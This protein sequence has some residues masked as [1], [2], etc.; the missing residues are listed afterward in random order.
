MTQREKLIAKIRARPAE[1]DAGDVI[2]VLELFGWR[3]DR[4]TGSHM[5]FV[6]PGEALMSIPLVRGRRVKRR[7]LNTLSRKL[8]LD[9]LP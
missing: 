9:E 1:A 2:G 6:K 5:I 7:Y 4:Q 3:L 8:G